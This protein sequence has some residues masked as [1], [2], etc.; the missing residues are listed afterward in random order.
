MDKIF[1]LLS[2]I[3]VLAI[4]IA[5]FPAGASVTLTGNDTKF[6]SVVTNEGIPLLNAIPDAMKT[7]FFDGDGSSISTVGKNQS[8]ALDIFVI[9]IN[10]YTVSDPV[11]P[12]QDQVLN[13]TSI[14]KKD[15][16]EYQGLVNTCGSCISKMNQMYPDL[17]AQA[18]KTSEM[19]TQFNK[20]SS[21][22]VS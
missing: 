17:L 8:D 2:G 15:L 7:G 18:N 1:W 12:L 10:G 13:T 11:K 3:S 19:I 5:T 9:K 20:E 14:Y 6:L 16:T 4:C 21:A 22:P